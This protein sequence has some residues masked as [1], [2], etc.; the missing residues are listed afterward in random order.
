M[1]T[2]VVV[3]V[4]GKKLGAQ[5]LVATV[6]PARYGKSQS[7]VNVGIASGCGKGLIGSSGLILRLNRVG[8]DLLEEA[9]GWRRLAREIFAKTALARRH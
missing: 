4:K 2:C 7:K 3:V 1:Y 8:E 5:R 6:H 9:V